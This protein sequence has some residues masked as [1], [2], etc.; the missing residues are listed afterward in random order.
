MKTTKILIILGIIHSTCAINS[1]TQF[2]YVACNPSGAVNIYV[3]N[4]STS[5]VVAN[6]TSGSM[7]IDVRQIV[8]NPA[9]NRY[10]YITASL[11]SP[12]NNSVYVVDITNNTLVTSITTNLP[13]TVSA[14]AITPDGAYVCVAGTTQLSVISTSTNTATAAPI[15][16]TG[17]TNAD[18]IAISPT[19]TSPPYTAYVADSGS[20]TVL[21]ISISSGGIPTLGTSFTVGNNGSP[22]LGG[23]AV[24]PNGQTLYVANGSNL[25]LYPVTNLGGTPSVGTGISLAGQQGQQ[26]VIILPNGTTAYVANSGSSSV[27]AVNLSTKAVTTI[28]VGTLPTFLASTTDSNYVYVSNLASST[29]SIISTATNT[30]T[31]TVN[32][33]AT[34]EGIAIVSKSSGTLDATFGNYGELL[35]PISRADILKGT[36]IT[37][38]NNIVIA[39][40]TQTTAPTAFLAE[41]TSNGSLNTS[42]FNS[43]GSTPGYQTLLPSGITQSSANGVTIDGSGNILIAGSAIQSSSTNF[44]VARYTSAGILDT[45]FNATNHG[46]VTTAIGSGAAANGIG[47]QSAAQSNRIIVGGCSV[48]NGNPVF[49]LACYIPSGTGVG[50]LYSSFGTSGIT[51]T[52]IGNIAI[53]RAIAIIP[54]TLGGAT[55]DYIIAAGIVDNHIAL[56]RYTAAGVLDTTF[57]TSGI[58]KP[59]ISGATS[60][61]AYAVT[62]D[63][64][65][66]NIYVAGSAVVSGI[67]QSL[68]LRCTPGGALDT[69]F[70]ST[71]YALQSILYGSEYY[72]LLL[73]TTPSLNNNCIVTGGYAIGAL[74]NEISMT[75][76]LPSGALDPYYGT[77]GTSLTTFGTFETAANAIGIQSTGNAIAAGTAD[78]TFYVSR[79]LE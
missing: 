38:S 55:I 28:T 1:S 6:I 20:N 78:G 65:T 10:A 62:I 45:T 3:I 42:G 73:Q 15:T 75:R 7:A 79:F 29:V 50:T 21:P 4:G 66:N 53:I 11:S 2:A 67:N 43:S 39:G 70:N 34:A 61:Q 77:N 31:A 51:T 47:I 63:A 60:T 44:F 64:T 71:G 56:A 35:T 16:I 27:C 54:S 46:W 24:T 12:S 69:T 41:Y 5:S 22:F 48:Q 72:S 59:S 25:E 68:I 40:V 23:L 52:S 58:F 9:N 14:L 18:F 33:G 76:Y 17:I 26:Q 32:V 37:S 74:S 36:A 8:I 57:G 30:V 13:P 19:N 49:A